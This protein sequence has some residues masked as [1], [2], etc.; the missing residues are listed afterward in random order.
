MSST[1]LGDWTIEPLASQDRSSF[2]CGKP[3]LNDFLKQSAGQYGRKGLA[4]TYVA[5]YQEGDRVLGFYAVSSGSVDFASLPKS[6][7]K[8]LPQR[9]PI[10]VA[11][12]GQLAVDLSAR[13]RGLGGI[14]LIDALRRI[15]RV[16]DETG[17]RAVQVH[18]KDGEARAFYLKYGFESMQDDALHLYLSMKAVRELFRRVDP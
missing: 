6:G 1:Q 18:A 13:G 4:R 16:S 12:I 11:L 14:L 10:P 7:R 9:I 8:G 3:K 17:I 2:D 15:G 5:L